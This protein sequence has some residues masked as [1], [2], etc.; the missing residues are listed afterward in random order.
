MAAIGTIRKRLGWL[1]ILLMVLGI[2][3]FLLMD[4]VGQGGIGSGAREN[5]VAEIDGE[6]ISYTEFSR[7]YEFNLETSRMTGDGAAL[8][9][10]EQERIREQTWNELLDRHILHEHYEDLGLGVSD[11]EFYEM[12]QGR[13][14]NP[15]MRQQFADPSTGQ[16][17]RAMISQYLQNLGIDEPGTE[18]GTKR[19]Q[20]QAFE[21]F[22]V[23]DQ[24]DRKYRAMIQNG[25]TV[26]TWMAEMYN[27][28]AAT[29]DMN[30]VQLPLAEVPQAQFEITDADLKEHLKDNAAEFEQD[31]ARGMRFVVFPIVPSAADSAQARAWMDEKMA[32]LAESEDDS[33]FIGLYSQQD[34]IPRERLPRAD[35]PSAVRDTLANAPVG[36]VVGPYHD[37][38]ALTAVKAVAAGPVPDSVRYARIVFDFSQIQS[39]EQ[40][41][42]KLALVDSIYTLL[43]S[44][45]ADFATLA[46]QYFED[47]ATRMNGGD[48]GW[49]TRSELPAQLG[50]VEELADYVFFT[51]D[52]GAVEQIPTDET[53]LQIVTKTGSRS[54]TDGLRLA[55]LS[56]P[57]YASG[58][59]ERAVYADA[60]LFAGNNATR[61]AFDAATADM[62][63]R[64][65]DFITET[66]RTLLGVEGDARE[67]IRTWV[68]GE[69]TEVG[70]VSSPY[71]V[72]NN[73]IVAVLTQSIPDGTPSVDDIRPQLEAA[74]LREKRAAYLMEQART[75]SGSTLAEK[76]AA[77]GKSVQSA[78]AV[79]LRSPSLPGVGQAP[80]A[81]G[82]AL[83]ADVGE[84]EV[85]EGEGSVFLVSPTAK[86]PAPAMTDPAPIR[87]QYSM[88]MASAISTRARQSLI[89][90]ADLEDNRIRFF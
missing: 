38:G 18:P 81:V 40:Y 33:T 14:M 19:R 77:L 51:M 76:A 83:G 72:G 55:Y 9:D 29:L 41:D 11:A 53:T 58:E 89:E 20:W 42:A 1:L 48:M 39:Q 37:N 46:Q 84:I 73:L 85:V 3:G 45:D 54:S 30:F 70:D 8:D 62:N 16:V 68:F 23:R 43:D 63:V 12:V 5:T 61:E 35:W 13:F 80:A 21:T 6:K 10:Q 71:K 24:M 32:E 4:S 59:T 75:A 31:A 78:P 50:G 2:G 56:Y 65:A 60:S 22:L 7:L 17:D 90:A 88:S 66:Q 79:S 36:A 74:V 15:N 34:R 28:E 86:N 67:F 87:S 57:L 52:E 47:P 25:T 26:P 82:A 64:T 27:S 49:M 69:D 44:L